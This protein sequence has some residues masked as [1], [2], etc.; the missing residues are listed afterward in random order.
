MMLFL[1]IAIAISMFG[2]GYAAGL[3]DGRRGR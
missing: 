2:L 3:A 1:L